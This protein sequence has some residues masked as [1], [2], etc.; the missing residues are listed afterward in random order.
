MAPGHALEMFDED[1]VDDGARGRAHQRHHLGGGLFRKDQAKTPG[2]HIQQFYQCRGFT[3]IGYRMAHPGQVATGIRHRDFE[4]QSQPVI[5]GIGGIVLVGSP[6]QGKHLQAGETRIH[7]LQVLAF[8]LGDFGDGT[9]HH[10]G[11]D[12]QFQQ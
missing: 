8:A 9:Q 1:M 10:R 3:R 12:R 7:L 5:A 2:H 11:R 6:T 4:R